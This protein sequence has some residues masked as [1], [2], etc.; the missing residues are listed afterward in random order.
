MC[1]HK[2]TAFARSTF[3]E[4]LFNLMTNLPP[5]ITQLTKSIASYNLCQGLNLNFLPANATISS[6]C[7]LVELLVV[8]HVGTM[9]ILN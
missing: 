2:L 9:K 3:S 8:C 1:S 4:Y 5:F 7:R 6:C